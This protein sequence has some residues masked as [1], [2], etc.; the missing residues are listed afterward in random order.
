M[1]Y[2]HFPFCGS[3]CLYCGFYSTVA[4]QDPSVFSSYIRALVNE[5]RQRKPWLADALSGRGIETVY[6][7]G[8]TPSLVPVTVLGRL[9]ADL[10]K[11][12]GE[13]W[14]PEEV[15]IEVNP[16]DVTPER[17]MAWRTMGINRV[18]IGVQS[19]DDMELRHC[20]RRH[21]AGQAIE[22]VRMLSEVFSNVSVDLI[23]GLPE[24]T[25]ESLRATV[26]GLTAME[27]QHISAY[28]L[29][30]EPGTPLSRL[31]STGRARTCSEDES[32]ERYEAVC[33]ALSAAGYEHYEISNFARPGFRSRHNSAYWTGHP[34][35]GLGPGAASYDGKRHR[36][37]VKPVLRE[38]LQVLESNATSGT[39]SSL[40]EEE[41][42]TTEQLR[43][44]YLLTRLRRREGF[45]LREYEALFGAK[46]LQRL[47][48]SLSAL[49][50]RGYLRRADGRVALTYPA[51]VL[52]S[53]GVVR[54]LVSGF[55]EFGD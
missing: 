25:R 1:L 8:G 40:Y 35:L 24:Q 4:G 34:Y 7:G 12:A 28:M 23:V 11:E 43:D 51:G 32:E 2:I 9:L 48:D 5:F 29:E 42:L 20:G 3:R 53:D 54:E 41:H 27:P 33:D 45:S 30:V 49:E 31:V 17:V 16:D 18:S 39:V 44:E 37:S 50:S 46:E 19:L 21:K 38:Y 15:T 14:R 6:L 22:A 36:V 55:R 47:R 10:G 52:W 13:L 26:G